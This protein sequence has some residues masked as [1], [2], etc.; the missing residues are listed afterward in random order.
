M[1]S[2]LHVLGNNGDFQGELKQLMIVIDKYNNGRFDTFHL[3]AVRS[4]LN[5]NR[6]E[7]AFVM[8]NTVRTKVIFYCLYVTTYM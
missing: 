3:E 7:D 4:L 8:L 1:S 5:L 2:L 6:V